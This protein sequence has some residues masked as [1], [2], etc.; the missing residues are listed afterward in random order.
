MMPKM[1]NIMLMTLVLILTACSTTSRQIVGKK[2]PPIEPSQV[3]VYDTQ[4]NDYEQIAFI[5]AS[6]KNALAFSDDAMQDVAIERLKEEAA[7]LGANGIWLNTTED[8]VT[9]SIGTG[10][11]MGGRNVIIGIGMSMPITN[12]LLKAVAIYIAPA[13]DELSA[14]TKA[15]KID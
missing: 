6:S 3:A 4:P 10:S 8:E 5:Q 15:N 14:E 2:R 9:G 7:A 11:G 12:K 13:P 1:H